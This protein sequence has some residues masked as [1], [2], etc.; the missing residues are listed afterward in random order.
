MPEVISA[1]SCRIHTQQETA[2]PINQ[3]ILLD[4][5]PTGE[6]TASNFMLVSSDTPP[7][8]TARC[9]CATTI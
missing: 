5:R 9:W 8:R 4:N 6:A 2:M 7:C 3:Q 1:P